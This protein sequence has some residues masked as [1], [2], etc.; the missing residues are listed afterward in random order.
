M[1]TPAT[2]PVE[3]ALVEVRDGVDVINRLMIDRG[4]QRRGYGPALPTDL[5][6]RLS[7]EPDVEMITVSHRTGNAPIGRAAR[8]RRIRPCTV[9]GPT[10]T[11]TSGT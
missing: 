4:A 5:A 1:A 3:F 11:P 6:R 9:R 7:L 10:R 8:R 2:G